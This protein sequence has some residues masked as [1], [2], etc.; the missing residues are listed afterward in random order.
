[1]IESLSCICQDAQRFLVPHGECPLSCCHPC[2]CQIWHM[3][4]Q[5]WKIVRCP[6]LYAQAI[7]FIAN[8]SLIVSSSCICQD[9]QRFLVPHGECPLSCCHP[10]PCQ[11]WQMQHQIWKVVRCPHLHAQAITFI[12]NCSVIESLSCICQDAQKFLVPHG[13]CPL[14]SCHPCPCQIW[15]MQHQLWKIVRCPHLYAQAITF[16][17][18]CS[19]IESLSCI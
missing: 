13:E 11:I 8:G 9:A 14:S 12:A 17:A 19:V 3:Q 1:M 18:N 7:T 15:Q 6:Y 2:P 4:H 16:I 10:C 5:L